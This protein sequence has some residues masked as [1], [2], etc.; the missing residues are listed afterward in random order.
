MQKIAEEYLPEAERISNVY[1]RHPD[2]DESD[3]IYWRDAIYTVEDEPQLAGE[4][5]SQ[6]RYYNIHQ[7][8]DIL[9]YLGKGIEQHDDLEPHGHVSISE[10]RHRMIGRIQL[11]KEFEP[12]EGDTHDLEIRFSSG[13]AGFF[14]TKYEV[15]AYRLICSNGAKGFV[16]DLSFEQ[17]HQDYLNPGLAFNAIDS[18]VEGVDRV[19]RRLADAHEQELMNLDES[20]LLLRDYGIDHVLENPTSDLL[21]ALHEEVADP[22]NPTLKETYDAATRALTHYVPDDVPEYTVDDALER[23]ARLLD[24]NGQLP[25]AKEIGERTVEKRLNEYLEKDET[26]IEQYWEDEEESLLELAEMH[27]VQA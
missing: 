8:P 4:V 20:L 7:Y 3:K 1:A 22:R 18:I 11:G 27:G 25:G 26:E 2:K 15:G 17:T 14:A 21:N 10:S 12:V 23:A 9:R 16:S 13:H 19:E 6:G 24:Q 5:S